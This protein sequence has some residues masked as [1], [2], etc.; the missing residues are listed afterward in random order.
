VSVHALALHTCPAAHMRAHEPQLFTSTVRSRHV[1]PQF[2]S[3][4][5]QLS[6]HVPAL[7]I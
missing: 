7:Q 6:A 1:P 3:P 2:V 5:A 4:V